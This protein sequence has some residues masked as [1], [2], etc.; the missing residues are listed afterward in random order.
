MKWVWC[1]LNVTVKG[2]YKIYYSTCVYI[3]ADNSMNTC[4][5]T[6]IKIHHRCNLLYYTSV[7]SNTVNP[8]VYTWKTCITYIM[9]VGWIGKA[10]F[11]CTVKYSAWWITR[12]THI[13]LLS[14]YWVTECYYMQKLEIHLEGWVR[15]KIS[16]RIL[17]KQNSR[18]FSSEYLFSEILHITCNIYVLK[19]LTL[20]VTLCILFI[21]TK[22]RVSA[23]NF[24]Y[25]K[26]T[27]EGDHCF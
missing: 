22:N 17:L 7:W 18:I 15:E 5:C 13:K 2:Y 19:K 10:C 27:R 8:N 12:N 3:V 25:H 26:N 24:T 20:T 9:H 14:N 16:V 6:F 11:R 4:L 1:A 21:N 23:V